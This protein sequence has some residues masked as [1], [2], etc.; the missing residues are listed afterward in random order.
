MLGVHLPLPHVRQR[1]HCR[2]VAGATALVLTLIDLAVACDRPAAR[3]GPK[4]GLQARVQ[5][6]KRQ[7]VAARQLPAPSC[8]W[9]AALLPSPQKRATLPALLLPRPLPPPPSPTR[10]S[11]ATPS[12]G[13]MTWGCTCWPCP[14]ATRTQRCRCARP[15][16]P[17]T[18]PSPWPRC[19]CPSAPTGWWARRC[20]VRHPSF[21]RDIICTCRH[22]MLAP[23]V[24]PLH[25]APQ[26]AP[27]RSTTLKQPTSH[28][29][30][31]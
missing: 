21:V 5:R 8:P 22:S 12:T 24:T 29:A 18:S 13:R 4:L 16:R 20:K 3:S 6:Q 30:L 28:S 2:Q 23:G 7:L 17:R 15:A 10:L 14:V 11:Q 9:C 31:P 25:S 27:R 26:L 19:G 1:G